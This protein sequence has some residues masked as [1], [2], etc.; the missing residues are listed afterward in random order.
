MQ[1]WWR[2]NLTDPKPLSGGVFGEESGLE[3]N[4]CAF[5]TEIGSYQK[6]TNIKSGSGMSGISHG[7][8]NKV[9]KLQTQLYIALFRFPPR[10]ICT[11]AADGCCGSYFGSVCPRPG[12]G[13][14]NW[15]RTQAGTVCPLRGS[16][17]GVRP[18]TTGRCGSGS[19]SGQTGVCESARPGVLQADSAA[20]S[21]FLPSAQKII[22][23]IFNLLNFSIFVP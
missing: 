4:E 12:T 23:F 9:H 1:P 15:R 18:E 8:Q 16:S 17:C 2:K 22:V 5:I 7:L 13:W 6:W 10:L 20:P 14:K 19:G 11:A 21:L 3:K